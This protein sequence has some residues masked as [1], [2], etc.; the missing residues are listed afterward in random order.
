M[1]PK[2]RLITVT[3]NYSKK[4]VIDLLRKNRIEKVLIINRKNQLKGMIT[5]KDIQKSS[6]YPNA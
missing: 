6:T 3:E 2:D 1:T 4:K 5:F